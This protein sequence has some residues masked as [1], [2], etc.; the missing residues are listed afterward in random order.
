M[1][2]SKFF[3]EQDERHGGP[4]HWPGVRGFPFRGEQ[5][6]LLKQR[7]YDAVPLVPDAKHRTFDLSDPHD[8]AEYAWVRD[9]VLGGLFRCDYIEYHWDDKEKKMY[10]YVEWSQIYA[11]LPR[12]FS[13]ENLEHGVPQR[14]TLR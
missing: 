7:E 8:S 5:F 2:G 4:L 14:F 13:V 11:Q 10:I 6:P 3:G 1:T 12:N 9:R